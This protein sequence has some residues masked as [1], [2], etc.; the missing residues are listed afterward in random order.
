MRYRLIKTSGLGDRR[1]D[2]VGDLVQLEIGKEC[3]INAYKDK[4][5]TNSWKTEM[6]NEIQRDT[7]G[8]IVSTPGC[9][10]KLMQIMRVIK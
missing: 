9:T 6:V 10:Y 5:I 8:Y 4:S 3:I 7:E 2:V 1:V